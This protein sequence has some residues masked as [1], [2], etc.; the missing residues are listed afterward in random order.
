MLALPISMNFLVF[1]GK[2]QRRR[3]AE[4]YEAKLPSGTYFTVQHGRDFTRTVILIPSQGVARGDRLRQPEIDVFEEIRRCFSVPIEFGK[5][6][7][8]KSVVYGGG[9]LGRDDPVALCIDQ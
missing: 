4:I 1:G 8:V 9:D 3:M 5:H 2:Y 7:R 6:E